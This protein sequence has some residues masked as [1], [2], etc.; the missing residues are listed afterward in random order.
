MVD[1]GSTPLANAYLTADQ[2]SGSER[3]YPLRA[4]L[5]DACFLVQLE[6]FEPPERIFSD[7]AYLSSYSSTWVAHCAA[8]AE[9]MTRQLGLDRTSF[10]VEIASN[11]GCLL[12]NFVRAGIPSLGIEPA[13]NVAAIARE[14]GVPTLARFFG[15][16]LAAELAQERRADLI[17][18]NNVLAHVPDL[19]DFVAGLATLL[20]P[21]GTLTVEVPHL[22]RLVEDRQFDTIY[23]EHFS[24]FSC[25]VL[26]GVFARHGLELI[27]VERL[28]THGGSLRAFVRHRGAAVRA[29][30]VDELIAEERAHGLLRQE[31]YTSYGSAVLA[32]KLRLLEF[33]V[34]AK[35][36]KKTIVG[37]GAPAKGNTLLNYCGIG[38]DFIEFTVDANPYK[39]GLYLPGTRIPI[40]APVDL[41]AVRPDLI[42]ILPWNIREEIERQLAFARSWGARF[43]VRSPELMV[44]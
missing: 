36:A 1:L 34:Q 27:G 43:V 11:D 33:F 31:T 8:H 16:G 28:P 40:R 24:Y 4:L 5:C 35:L 25:A 39:Q 21:G 19:N 30:R 12:R 42:F 13:E 29:P 18:A 23:H 7:Y 2:L 44:A 22:L 9:Q 3:Y 17:V 41:E 32:E 15:T 26:D 37:Y 14:A 6:A 20:A 10:V 38:R